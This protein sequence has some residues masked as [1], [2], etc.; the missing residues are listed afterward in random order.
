VNVESARLVGTPPVPDDFAFLCAL[1]GDPRVGA[2]FGGVRTPDEVGV[3]LAHQR[4]HW[5]GEG[6]GY[7]IWRDRESGEPVARGGLARA[8]IEREPAVEVGWSVVPDRWGEG[9]ATELGAA[10]LAVAAQL[11]FD[12]LVAFT[13]PANVA[14]RRVMEKLG[15]TYDR[16]FM[17]GERGLHVLY[18]FAVA[19]Q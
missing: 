16:E 1:Y 5:T 8:E 17:R 15:M 10:S 12:E 7:W 6:F 4:E 3:M 9:L 13:L 18:R 14:S 19:T 11:G 2:T